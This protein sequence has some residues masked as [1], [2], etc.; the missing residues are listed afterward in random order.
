[1][2]A[3]QRPPLN[4]TSGKSAGSATCCSIR[5]CRMSR[6]VWIGRTYAEAPDIDG[7]VFV[8]GRRIEAGQIVPCEIVATSEYDLIGERRSAIRGRIAMRGS[9]TRLSKRRRSERVNGERGNLMSTSTE[10]SRPP[11]IDFRNDL[12][13][14]ES[15]HQ[16]SAGVGGRAVL[17]D[18]LRALSGRRCMCSSLRR[19]PI[20]SMAF[21]PVGTTR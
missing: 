17:A 20:G 3:Q 8:T 15:A 1:M 21:T 18:R 19:A 2:A 10:K 12:Q 4:G 14:A 7:V 6:D 5:P 9:G 16:H 11:L 13:C